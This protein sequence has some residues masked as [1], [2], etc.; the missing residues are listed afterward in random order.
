[1]TAPGRNETTATRRTPRF[2]AVLAGL[3]SL[4]LI[5]GAVAL[6]LE[7]WRD[8]H[9]ARIWQA[10][11]ARILQ[12]QDAGRVRG[13][14]VFYVQLRAPVRDGNY[15]IRWSKLQVNAS[16]RP[17]AAAPDVGYT[18]AVFVAPEPPF[19]IKPASSLDTPLSLAPV[20][21]ALALSGL[22]FARFA[23]SLHA[24]RGTRDPHE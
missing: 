3:S 14:F 4:L 18:L 2:A 24:R 19:D 6:G 21:A 1:M 13:G 8:W 9:I 17:A 11:V 23:V 10:S 15:V 22:F 16:W 12:V 20:I 5:G 7:V